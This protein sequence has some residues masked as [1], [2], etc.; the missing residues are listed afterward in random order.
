MDEGSVIRSFDHLMRQATSKNASDIHIQPAA[1]MLAIR[2]RVDG[3]LQRQDSRPLELAAPLVTRVKVLANM[4]IAERRLPQDGTFSYKVGN[5]KFNVRCSSFPTAYGERMVLR[6]LSSS[7]ILT[8]MNSLG[9][10]PDGLKQVTDAAKHASGLILVTGPTGSGKT[11]TL[12]SILRTLDAVHLNIL[13]L[14]DPIEIRSPEMSQSQ[15]NVRSGFTFTRGL[16]SLLRQD[17]DVIMVGEMRDEETARIAFQA[18]LTGHLVLSTLHTTST[19]DTIIRLLDIGLEPYL[20]ASSLSVL[21]SQR[22]VRTLCPSC[23]EQYEPKGDMKDSLGFSLPPLEPY[24]YRASGCPECN[25]TGYNGRTGI[26]EVLQISEEMR[27]MIKEQQSSDRFKHLLRESKVPTLRREG[28]RKALDGTTDIEEV[29][30][31]T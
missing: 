11:S 15:V 8:D 27:T 7:Y 21:I 13:T 17:P 19:V 20:V 1:T 22:L 5:R 30:R 10:P 6:L 2:F 18:S 31:V 26:F 28:V 12:H 23:R 24:L 16:R 4:D 29:M 14:E 3:V 9:L 25:F